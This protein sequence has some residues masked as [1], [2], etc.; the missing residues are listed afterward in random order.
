MNIIVLNR[1]QAEQYIGTTDYIVISI[2]D[3][4]SKDAKFIED[5]HRIDIL[6]L[7]FHDVEPSTEQ[8]IKDFYGVFIKYFTEYKAKNIIEFVNMYK[9][10][11]VDIIVHCEAGISRSAGVAAAISKWLFNT[12]EHFFKSFYPNMSVYRTILNEVDKINETN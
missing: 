9:C 11:N 2:T 10:L 7:K 6:R 1:K 12:D 4:R 3:P 8:Y 5:K